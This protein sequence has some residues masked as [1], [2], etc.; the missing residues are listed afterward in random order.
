[1]QF[2]GIEKTAIGVNKRCVSSLALGVAPGLFQERFVAPISLPFVGAVP[3][4]FRFEPKLHSDFALTRFSV[5]GVS[6][7]VLESDRPELSESH[8]QR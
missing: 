2:C 1:M 7:L 6:L 4:A 5:L 3:R 8:E